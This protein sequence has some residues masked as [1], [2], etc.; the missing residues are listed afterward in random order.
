MLN[1]LRLFA[2]T[3]I[4]AVLA[5]GAANGAFW[6]WS[7]TS[8]TNSSVDPTINWREGM[9]PSSV[10]DSARAMMARAAEY[11]DDIS[12][13]VTTGGTATAYTATSN[14]GF[15][16]TPQMGQLFAFTMHAT[17]GVAPTLAVDG[18]TAWPIQTATGVAV[19]AGVLIQDSPYSAKFNGSAWV[20]RN[21]YAT[22]VTVPIGAMLPYTGSSAPNANFVLPSGQCISRTTYATYFAQV[23]TTFGSCD[24]ITTFAVPDLRGQIPVALDNMGGSA[25]SRLTNNVNGC[26]TAFTSIGVTCANGNES[27]TLTTAQIPAHS[28]GVTDPGHTHIYTRPDGA[29][30]N[31][32]AGGSATAP[33]PGQSTGSS[34]TGI[35]IQNAGGGGAHATVMP[36]IGV[37]YILRVL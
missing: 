33:A 6:Q 32:G 5:A 26:G 20:L 31:P 10:N 30:L 7:H 24:G 28:H 21:F 2:T 25:A 27:R 16:A 29:F 23:S 3:I 18:G 9:A 1:N 35:T 17:N 19:G 11:R 22:S 15:D 36:V 12:G 14:Q 8:S 37:T 4:V 13:S 34:T